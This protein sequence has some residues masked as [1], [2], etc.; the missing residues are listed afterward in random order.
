MISYPCV[1]RP[2]GNK[3]W[4]Y[5]EDAVDCPEFLIPFQLLT[6]LAE[7]VGL[8][9]ELNQNFHEFLFLQKE[10]PIDRS[11]LEA[12]EVFHARNSSMSQAEYDAAYIYKVVI[13][14]K[15]DGY[16]FVGENRKADAIK[17]RQ[18]GYKFVKSEDIMIIHA[19][20]AA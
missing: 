6:K 3:Y 8:E 4:F 18:P 12:N 15:K 19:A 17:I 2:F 13:F 16:P 20:D 10:N 9:L 5:L 7:E 11:L 1:N 14:K